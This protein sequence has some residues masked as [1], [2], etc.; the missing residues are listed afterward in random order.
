MRLK[1]G[2]VKNLLKGHMSAKLLD[3]FAEVE[4]P[5]TNGEKM[6]VTGSSVPYYFW[7][8]G[9]SQ[10][11]LYKPPSDVDFVLSVPDENERKISHISQFRDQ[12]Y[13]A[14]REAIDIAGFEPAHSNKDRYENIMSVRAAYT[15]EQAQEA[16]FGTRIKEV[17]DIYGITELEITAPVEVSTN[18]DTMVLDNT[19]LEAKQF[20]TDT[21]SHTSLIGHQ[22]L[23]SSLGFKIARNTLRRAFDQ[24]QTRPGDIIDA[25]NIFHCHGYE[26]D[27]DLLHVM[28]VVALAHQA[29]T[30][31]EGPEYTGDLL[32]RN[33]DEL[34]ESLTRHYGTHFSKQTTA[35]AIDTW[36]ILVNDSFPSHKAG[37]PILTN[38]EEDFI[39]NF[40]SPY[41]GDPQESIQPDLLQYNDA[42][43]SVFNQNSDLANKIKSCSFFQQR[44]SYRQISSC[45]IAI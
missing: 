42:L 7:Q 13:T 4:N 21:L 32:H 45:E 33:I 19:V 44:I 36:N 20:T 6:I 11:Y 37:V 43:R 38:S 24:N 10:N 5:F 34:H 12:M 39:F 8:K 40:L 27:P 15:P 29:P 18:M 3:S 2:I 28:T 30:S 26:H 41:S 25:H 22:S 31:F 1:N 23:T 17:L 35:T 16:I 9:L 14:S